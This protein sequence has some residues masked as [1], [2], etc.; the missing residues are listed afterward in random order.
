MPR[1][2]RHSVAMVTIYHILL[3]QM[4]IYSNGQ[5]EY[6]RCYYVQKE[7]LNNYNKLKSYGT[8]PEAFRTPS[9]SAKHTETNLVR[10]VLN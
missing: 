6:S 5:I 2:R 7:S 8:C 1:S 10:A 4:S 3:A 9:F